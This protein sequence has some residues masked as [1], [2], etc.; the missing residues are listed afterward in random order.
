M[1]NL[2]VKITR[3]K[4]HK[5]QMIIIFGVDCLRHISSTIR[6]PLTMYILA[7]DV[8][9]IMDLTLFF[10]SLSGLIFFV[11]GFFTVFHME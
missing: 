11:Y 7:I 3:C 9:K 8:W 2:S 1:L 5:I 6:Y 10:F 4:N